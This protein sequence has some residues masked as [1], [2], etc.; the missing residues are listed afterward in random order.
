MAFLTPYI[1]IRDI[2][3]KIKGVTT[4]LIWRP[5]IDIYIHFSY[6]LFEYVKCKY[7]RPVP[8][9]N[10]ALSLSIIKKV[11]LAGS[12]TIPTSARI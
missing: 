3:P 11:F 9:T 4:S 7:I 6:V 12:S 10:I 8:Q 2:P 1:V 5:V